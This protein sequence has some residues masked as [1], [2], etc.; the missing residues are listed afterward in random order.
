[1][2][3]TINEDFLRE[4]VLESASLYGQLRIVHLKYHLS[5]VGVLTPQHVEQYN[6]LRGYTSGNPCENIP[7][8]HDPE[9]WKLHNN[10]E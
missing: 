6:D 8:G 5:M 2:N 9:L 10:C 7:E 1:M 3:G 4:K